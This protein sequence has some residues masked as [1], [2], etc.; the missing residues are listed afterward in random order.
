MQYDHYKSYLVS[1]DAIHRTY[2]EVE[3]ASMQ[4]AHDIVNAGD[5]Y[6]LGT[7]VVDTSLHN[8]EIAAA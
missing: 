3:A 2:Y 1:V 6:L 8:I 4:D 7:D 5:A